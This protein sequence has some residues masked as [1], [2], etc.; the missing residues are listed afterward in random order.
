MPKPEIVWLEDERTYAEIVRR[1]AHFSLVKYTRGG[2]DYEILMENNEFDEY[3]GNDDEE[4]ADG[5]QD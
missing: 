3:Q 2:I 1:G 4:G 5:D